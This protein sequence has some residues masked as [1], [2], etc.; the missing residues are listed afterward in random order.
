MPREDYQELHFIQRQY[1]ITNDA[2]Q[3]GDSFVV[4]PNPFKGFPDVPDSSEGS[5]P[6]VDTLDFWPG[7]AVLSEAIPGD[8]AL[9]SWFLCAYNE[10]GDFP[11]VGQVVDWQNDDYFCLFLSNVSPDCVLN[12]TL[13]WPVKNADIE[14]RAQQASPFIIV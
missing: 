13:W 4:F 5:D 11:I 1:R 6:S 14:Y 2:I 9:Y 10:G 3:D 7:K 12:L 8:P